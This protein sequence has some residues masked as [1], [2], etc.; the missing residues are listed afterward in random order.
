[1]DILQ[2]LVL[3]LWKN[4]TFRRRNKIQLIIEI[5]WPLFIFVILIY[6]RKRNYPYQQGQCHFPNKALPSAG[7]L[8]WIQGFLCNINNPCYSSPTQGETP[9]KVG[10]FDNSIISR[11][12]VDAQ[13]ALDYAA[14]QD[15]YSLQSL[16]SN[17]QKLAEKPGI[18]PSLPVAEFLKAN[19]KFSPYLLTKA[20]LSPETV[21]KLLNADLNFQ[22]S[23][24]GPE[25]QLKELLCNIEEFKKFLTVDGG[26]D[27][28]VDLQTQFCNLPTDV[29]QEA[30]R[31]FIAELDTTTLAKKFMSGITPVDLLSFGLSTDD[32]SKELVDIMTVF[33]SLTSFTD[34]S[35]EF[36]LLSKGNDSRES[37]QAFS[38]IICNRSEMTEKQI[39]SL[40]WYEDDNIMS[41]MRK[42]GS[43]DTDNGPHNHSNTFCKSLIQGIQMNP[44]SRIVWGVIKPILT[45]KL[46]Y[47]PDT[48]A[49]QQVMR[50]VNKTF[51]DLQIFRELNEVW[52]EVGPEILRIMETR[53]EIPLL[54]GLLQLPNIATPVNQRLEKTPWTA[55][56]IAHFLSSPSP[57]TPRNSGKNSTWRDIYQDLNSTITYL[58]QATECFFFNKLEG[59]TSEDQ[60]IGRA[61]ELLDDRQFWAGVVFVLPN[62]SSAELPP[63]IIY[64]IRMDIDDV[65]RTDKVKERF[66]EPGPEANPTNDMR[67]IWG[68]FVY[69]QDLVEKAVSYVLTNVEQ[70]IGIYVQQMPY[71]CFVDDLF[72]RVLNRTLPLFLTLAWIYSVAII[73]KGV[74]YEKEARLKETMKIM[75]LSTGT[76]WLS[77][78]ISSLVPF[79]LSS[80]LLITLLK[81]G[82]ILPY[83]NVVVLFF[84]L[85][86]F[87][88]ATI[89]QCFLISTFFSKANMAAACGG[90]IYFSLYLPY[91][92]FVVWQDRVTTTLKVF[93]SFLSP[94]AFG[95]GSEYFTQ[96]EEQG[97]GIQ[98]N[99][100]Q[101]S[102]VDGD[103]Y[104]FAA[105]I[106]MLYVDAVVYAGV[107][108]YIEAVFPGEYGVPRP[109]YFLFHINYWKGIP[110]E[111]D[112]PIPSAPEEQRKDCIEAD[113]SNL[114]L[115]VNISNLVKIYKKGAKMAVNHLNLK[116]YEGQITS[117]LGHNGAGKTTTIS[118]LTGLFPPTSGTVYI[119]GIDILQDVDTIRKTLGICPQ[120]NVLFDT[121]TVEEH[122]WFYGR[123]K[124]MSEEEVKAELDSWLE[125]VGLLHKRHEPTINLSGGMKRKLSVAIAFVG[126]SKVVV[127]DEPTAG[128][129]PYSRR[130]IWDMLLKYRK[131]RTIILSTHYMDEAELLGDRIAIISQ[132]RLRCCGSPLFLK[133]K[134]GSGYSLTV[135]KK[136]SDLLRN[137]DVSTVH[138][139][140]TRLG[141]WDTSSMAPLLSLAQRHFPGAS[142]VEESH[143]E[144]VINLPQRSIESR[145]LAV[146][147]FELDQ[148]LSDF[149]IS[150]YGL[151]DSKLEDIFLQVAEETEV[152]AEPELQPDDPQQAQK[153][154]KHGHH[155]EELK[156]EP[157]ETDLPSGAGQ[158]AL[159]LTGWDLTR[160]HLRALFIKRWLYARRSRRGIFA[161]IVL[162][163]VFV[164]V[165]LMVC[166]IVPKLGKYPPLELH[167]CMYGEQYT[168]FSNDVPGDPA[169]EKLLEAVMDMPSFDTKCM[170]KENSPTSHK[171]D[172][173][174]ETLFRRPQVPH[175]T[176]QMFAKG[177]WSMEMP[178][179]NCECSTKEILRILPECPE[180]AGGLPPPQVK[181][182]NGLILQNMTSYN[183]SDYLVKT[184]SQLLKKSM[185]IKKSVNELRY[186]GFSLGGVR[187]SFKDVDVSVGKIRT[188][189]SIPQNSTFNKFLSK[190][191]GFLERLDTPNNVKVWFNN[192]GWHSMVSFVNVLSNG[193]L[194]AGLPPD[195]PGQKSIT[196]Y[197]HPLN[198]TKNQL[199]QMAM[200]SSSVDVL[201]SVCVI[202]AMSFVPASFVLF[203][204][205][206]RASKAKHLQF[207]S[208]VQPVVYWVANFCWDMLNYTVPAFIVVLIFISFQQDAYV[209]KTNL[210]VLIML[211]LFYGWSITPL[212]YPA[213]FVFTLPSTAYIV[214]TSVNLFIGINGSIATFVLELFD[215]EH[216]QAVNGVLKKVLL[217]FPHYCLGRGLMDMAKSQ[218][219]ADTFERLGAKQTVDPFQW[220]VVGKNLFAMALEGVLFFIFTLMLQYKFFIGHR[221]FQ[222]SYFGLLCVRPRTFVS[223]SLPLG[224]EDE[225][226]AR[227]RKRVKSGKTN[228]D[229]LTMTNLTK[230]Y[231]AGT[232][233]AVNQLC[234][235]IPRGE[236]FGLLGVNGAGK[237]TTFRMLTGD[238]SITFG[239][240][241]LNNHSVLR[242]LDR[243]HQLMGYCPQFDAICN[244][245]TA[246]EHLEL[247]ARLRGVPE[248]SVSK[249]ARWG[250][251]KMGLSQYAKQESGGY[252]GGNKRKLSTA[253]A[254][255]GAPPVIFLDEPTTG[256]DPKA[257]RFLW[258]CILCF[259]REGRAVVL[260]SHSMEECEAL[261]NRMAIMV[262]GS[263]QCLGSVQHLKNR[264][265]DG[266]TIIIRLSDSESNSDTCPVTNYMK[267]SFPMIELKEQH[268]NVRHYQLPAH[269]CC[270]SR[271]FD[272]LA[273][274]HEE[275]GIT[276][277]SVSQTTLDQV[278]VN[279]AKD[280][281]DGDV[282]FA[283]GQTDN[284]QLKDM[285]PTN[286]TGQSKRG[287]IPRKAAVRQQQRT[288]SSSGTRRKREMKRSNSVTEDKRPKSRDN[289][290]LS[291]RGGTEAEL[292]QSKRN[293]KDPSSLFMVDT[294][295]DDTAM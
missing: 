241:F 172:S 276:D 76:L 115:G 195:P 163:A 201:L 225:D 291:G 254:L 218:A 90:I 178:S 266:Y 45:G 267:T 246:I 52:L 147:L 53:L 14:K 139:G 25:V 229:I 29:I 285:T 40:N 7:T 27:A 221:S 236:C 123:L 153:K 275:L 50:E 235:G 155:G 114:V 284:K 10:N 32:I 20:G 6:V 31:L 65:T 78:F 117:F 261:C 22:V 230:I 263:F 207:V 21:K 170:E 203:L 199:N 57:D 277:S 295:T 119:H 186:G 85:T 191:P 161:Q 61:L 74:V 24:L 4:I 283:Q 91:I 58:A 126:G 151:S 94:V 23:L 177:N 89:T 212:M 62:T 188:R 182:G 259:T 202:F 64:K 144:A 150:S 42:G 1:M 192:K 129:D 103:H 140:D 15:F 8:P 245:L 152:N 217:V 210:P 248:E 197:N 28:L 79:L 11:V 37:F 16:R 107:A 26:D 104:N 156:I 282:K 145:S 66:W 271:V 176:W 262:N 173:K 159:T 80:A 116:F 118:V 219:I 17:I 13:M 280:Q 131:E 109:W 51:Q 113:P 54:Q 206:E 33:A 243:V 124:G 287:G 198:L 242:E 30:Q 149:G 174:K 36:R 77:W 148:N 196:A 3:L 180:G 200:T 255:I 179:P 272:V 70:N 216:L 265:G 5:L 75:G 72:L 185:K 127:L 48:P 162:P 167:P 279:F 238:T 99:N 136:E 135:V 274:M 111:D 247:Y 233:P 281:T 141:K 244:L 224:P 292:R 249:V 273:T 19:E 194:R 63:N 12:F 164:L 168:F 67:Y 205:E 87:A 264:F 258:N 121:L 44:L 160:Q 86:A 98:W 260:T 250:V 239:E 96:Y 43:E 110:L 92:L 157:E 35:K 232:K 184:Y 183:V 101:S 211:L 154:N 257:K 278:F 208:G 234:L 68:G 138:N 189:Y 175:S 105:A 106:V 214:L 228:S 84:F 120:Y 268:Q 102:P 100:L 71:P 209:S 187:K 293:R 73:I 59:L 227:E 181:R 9:G 237:T 55:S 134:L 18:W 223:E 204:I 294:N 56:Q 38:R 220:D 231:K 108:C 125:D 69:V 256:M 252:S 39:Q 171:P 269:A 133:S 88:T 222:N 158:C 290:T 93:A 166:L 97:V 169:L 270:L 132:G 122:I 142:L 95:F 253:I 143:S 112:I 226:V 2:Q 286:G 215:D 47:A 128:V 60:L 251:K 41:F 130:S 46:L 146:F 83:S 190:L 165:A 49:V 288:T 81:L 137:G 82:N 240:A 213:S 34:I 289:N 193:L